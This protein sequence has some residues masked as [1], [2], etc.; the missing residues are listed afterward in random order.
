MKPNR[1]V[2]AAGL[3]GAVSIIGVWAASQFGVDVPGEVASA[4]TTV[5]T[6]GTGYVIKE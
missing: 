3:A 5:L 1:K 2:G 4:I 6:F